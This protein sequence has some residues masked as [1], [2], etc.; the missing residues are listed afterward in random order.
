MDIPIQKLNIEKDNQELKIFMYTV[1]GGAI[2]IDLPVDFQAIMAYNDNDAFNEVRKNDPPGLAIMVRKHAEIPIKKLMN[3]INMT[4][5]E[6][7]V[8]PSSITPAEVQFLSDPPP[9]VDRSVEKFI[10]S[11]MLVA[12][13]YVLDKRDQASLKRIIKKIKPNEITP[14]TTTKE[15]IA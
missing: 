11:L 5:T 1:Q 10:Y 2:K 14:T 13:K 7:S 9:V 4:N 6:P 12:E 3:S 15:G 8:Q